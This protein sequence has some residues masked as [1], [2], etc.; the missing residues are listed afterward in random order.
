TE[1]LG[2]AAY[3]FSELKSKKKDSPEKKHII[4]QMLATD[5]KNAAIKAAFQEALIMVECVNFSRR[6]GG[7]PGNLM[8]PTILANEAV[9]AAKGT[10]IKV[11]VWDKARIKKEKMGGLLGVSMG[12]AEEPR[13]IIMEY[14]GAAKSKKPVAFV[15]KG[16]TFDCGGISI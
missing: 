9:A 12:S 14:N 2:L 3:D 7:M 16:L 8:T 4:F 13:F 11:T 6:L 5:A 1:G 15:G 10:G